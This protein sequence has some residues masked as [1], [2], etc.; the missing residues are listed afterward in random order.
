[1]IT[2][3]KRFKALYEKV[4]N[5]E[6]KNKGKAQIIKSLDDEIERLREVKFFYTSHDGCWIWMNSEPNHIES[7]ICPIIIKKDDLIRIAKNGFNGLEEQ[8]SRVTNESVIDH[9]ERVRNALNLTLFAMESVHGDE[10]KA[11][12]VLHALLEQN[13]S[14]LT[15]L[16]NH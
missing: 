9:L 12:S 1:M 10:E 4:E 15:S 6:R 3:E 13:H 11:R 8:L 14:L 16:K 5:L 7:L 2:K